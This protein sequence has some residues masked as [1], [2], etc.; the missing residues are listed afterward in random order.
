MLAKFF[1]WDIIIFTTTDWS[2]AGFVLIGLL[3]GLFLRL[4]AV[5]RKSEFRGTFTGLAIVWSGLHIC[6]YISAAQKAAGLPTLL[7]SVVASLSPVSTFTLIGFLL[8]HLV[9]KV[10]DE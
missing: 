4:F 7:L 8:M 2:W 5:R 3:L 1:H 10:K 6:S 9:K